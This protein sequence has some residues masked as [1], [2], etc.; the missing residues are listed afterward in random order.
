MRNLNPIVILV[1]SLALLNSCDKNDEP[2]EIIGNI[3]IY[4]I[5]SYENVG[6]S[7]EIDESSVVLE[8]EPFIPYPEIISY[9]KSQHRFEIT[10]EAINTIQS[11]EI[12]L[13]GLAFALTANDK[14]VY[15]G[16]FWSELSSLICDWIII[17]S[18]D[19]V[20]T[21]HYSLSVKLGHPEDL[22]SVPDK[23]NDNRIFN[24]FRRD[25]KLIQ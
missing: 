21:N 11:A 6:S 23:R 24:I 7:F 9:D 4:L 10:E 12:P 5:D 22:V 3:D 17:E 16:Y 8:P 18:V 20:V 25:N 2:I 19:F 13:N 14:I 1:L 15:T